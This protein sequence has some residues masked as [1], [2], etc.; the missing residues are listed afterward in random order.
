MEG[1]PQTNDIFILLKIREALEAGGFQRMS[2]W[3][4]RV[5]VGVKENSRG[6][7]TVDISTSGPPTMVVLG[8]LPCRTNREGQPGV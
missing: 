5:M 1:S 8:R 3:G 7:G 2:W 6:G 4:K